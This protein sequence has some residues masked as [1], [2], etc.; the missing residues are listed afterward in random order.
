[1]ETLTTFLFEK[2]PNY[3]AIPIELFVDM[4]NIQKTIEDGQK[5]VG[6]FSFSKCLFLINLK[7]GS[8]H[9]GQ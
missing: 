6:K 2:S 8:F 5:N 4:K 3:E 9:L 7:D 1:M